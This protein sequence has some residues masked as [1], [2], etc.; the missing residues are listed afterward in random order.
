MKR[1]YMTRLEGWARWMLPPQEA[2]E[3]IADYRDIVADEELRRGLGKPREV[4]AP[5]TTKKAYRVWLAVYAVMAACVLLIGH[6]GAGVLSWELYR[7]CVFPNHL[8]PVFALAGTALALVWF[9]RQGERPK[10]PL[11]KR[12]A[13]V[14]ALLLAWT[15]LIFLYH[16]ALLHDMDGFV[17]MW[18]TTEYLFGPHGRTVS[19]SVYYFQIALCYLPLLTS[20]LAL[21]WL[22]KARVSDRRWAA[23]Y[24]LTLAAILVSL[25]TIAMLTSMEISNP[26]EVAL[27][28]NLVK[29]GGIAAAGLAGAGAA[30]C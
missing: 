24:I 9:R 18:G 19:R 28:A 17:S 20:F 23:A 15:G 3:V 29:C 11:P 2:E 22:V 14:L 26:V 1:D 4:I 30:L 25:E 21:Y 12:L 5:L 6:S 27:R 7:L 8:G 10:T 13:A 16:W